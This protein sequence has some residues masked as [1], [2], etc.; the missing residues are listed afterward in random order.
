VPRVEEVANPAVI[1]I[2]SLQ[3]RNESINGD[4]V[5]CGV[6]CGESSA[7]SSRFHSA[8]ARQ[9]RVLMEI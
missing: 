7:P 4:L 5:V 1:F 8:P 9:M 2:V 6:Q 3:K